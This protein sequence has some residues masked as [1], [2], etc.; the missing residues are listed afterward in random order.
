M[1]QGNCCQNSPKE[2]IVFPLKIG[3]ERHSNEVQK[4]SHEVGTTII[5]N[6]DSL[7]ASQP[8]FKMTTPPQFMNQQTEYYYVPSDRLLPIFRDRRRNVLIDNLDLTKLDRRKEHDQKGTK[9]ETAKLNRQSM[10]GKDSGKSIASVNG[11]MKNIARCEELPPS[12]PLELKP[13]PDSTKRGSSKDIFRKLKEGSGKIATS[14]RHVRKIPTLNRV[15]SST[16]AIHISTKQQPPGNRL[17]YQEIRSSLPKLVLK[18]ASNLMPHNNITSIAHGKCSLYRVKDHRNPESQNGFFSN[19]KYISSPGKGSIEIPIGSSEGEGGGV[20]ISKRPI[21]S[22]IEQRESPG[23]GK[24]TVASGDDDEPKEQRKF[25]AFL[26]FPSVKLHFKQSDQ[27]IS[28]IE[29]KFSADQKLDG[30]QKC[31][32][33]SKGALAPDISQRYDLSHA[34]SSNHRHEEI[35]EL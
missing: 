27:I 16:R 18:S 19:M 23:L 20:M 13:R 25:S 9:D 11:K 15:C 29:D 33:H 1:G 31:P 26:E 3:P 6:K 10:R 17:S 14:K 5:R 8:N 28:S 35:V 2:S 21:M 7:E 12:T 24:Y 30:D 32:R 22:D 34:H 4:N